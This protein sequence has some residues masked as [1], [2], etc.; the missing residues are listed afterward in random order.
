MI[1]PTAPVGEGGSGGS[2][3]GGT[4]RQ[5]LFGRLLGGKA[6]EN[7]FVG[8]KGG[9]GGDTPKTAGVVGN[10]GGGKG[11]IGFIG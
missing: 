10:S 6:E 5:W 7:R 9:S 3:P 2:P 8:F 4:I 1:K 11:W